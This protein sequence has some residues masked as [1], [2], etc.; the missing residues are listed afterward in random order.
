MGG[1]GG[2]EGKKRERMTSGSRVRK[3]VEGGETRQFGR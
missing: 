2:G 1:R 3:I